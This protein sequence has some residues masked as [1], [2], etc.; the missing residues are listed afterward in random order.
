MKSWEANMEMRL[1]L[2]RVML[3]TLCTK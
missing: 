2:H 1:T 3:G